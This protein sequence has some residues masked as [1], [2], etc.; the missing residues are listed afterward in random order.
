VI[1][2]LIKRC[3][4]WLWLNGPVVA[5]YVLA[6]WLTGASFMG[7]SP[8]YVDSIVAHAN[9]GGSEFWEFG[10]LFWRPLGRLASQALLPV[11]R[12]FVGADYRLNVWLTLLIIC[13]VCGLLAAVS[14]CGLVRAVCQKR[15]AANL[16]AIA[17]ILTSSL[18][19]Y[20]QSGT[21]YV[22]GLS[23][24]MLG[25]WLLARDRAEPARPMWRSLAAGVTLGIAVCLW[26]PYVWAIPAALASPLLLFDP[27]RRR[28][29]LTLATTLVCAI[30][31]IVSYGIVIALLGIHDLA[32]LKAWITAASHGQEQGGVARIIF[33]LP[34]SW[35]DMGRDGMFIKR[36]LLHD[37]FN[38][39]SAV[40][41]LRLSLWKLALFY[42]TLGAVA[43]TLLLSA[44][45]RKILALLVLNA[46]PL[47][48]F[49]FFFD[50]GAVERYFPLYPTLFLAL[51][52]TFASEPRRV[53][54]VAIPLVFIVAAGLTN[55]RVMWKSRLDAE[56]EVVADRVRDLVPNLKPGSRVVVAHLEDELAN[57]RKSYPFH[58][59]NR[60][61][62]LDVYALVIPGTVRAVNWRQMLAAQAQQ[63]WQSGGEVWV[64]RRLLAPRPESAWNWVEGDDK[65][66]SWTNL[67]AFFA[68][69]EMGQSSGGNDGFL[70]LPPSPKNQA[71]LGGG[72]VEQTK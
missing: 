53:W 4:E 18:L 68:Q 67:S 13:W 9:G 17:F 42:L 20:S 39:V 62:R 70:L 54:L 51:A 25:F 59:L 29:R 14:L 61:D 24:L 71:L 63:A 3:R 31:G 35:I 66:I 6:T 21:A 33:G 12:V 2:R 34:R 72:T 30:F 15:W 7:D 10:H 44:R 1:Q 16:T 65:R 8:Y 36:Y 28:L 48:V 45:G 46:V 60:A 23:F 40:D 57:F 5:V 41:L 47:L 37:P 27:D 43:V 49:A 64:S 38:P 50:G 19:N 52:W 26:F 56:Q 11:T 58:P 22:P 55:L 32:G 69:L